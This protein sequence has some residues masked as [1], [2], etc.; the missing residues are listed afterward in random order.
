[1]IEETTKDETE[2]HHFNKTI[3]SKIPERMCDPDSDVCL[4]MAPKQFLLGKD[5]NIYWINL[6]SAKSFLIFV[7]F[8]HQPWEIDWL[9]TEVQR[10]WMGLPTC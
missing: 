8:P 5:T 7:S 9:G 10:G 2:V 4:P 3:F 1:M 6:I